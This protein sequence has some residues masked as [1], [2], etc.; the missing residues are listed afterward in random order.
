MQEMFIAIMAM[1][2]VNTLPDITEEYRNSMHNKEYSQ[3]VSDTYGEPHAYDKCVSKQSKNKTFHIYESVAC[4]EGLHFEGCRYLEHINLFV[5]N[6]E[7]FEI[8]MDNLLE[9]YGKT[10]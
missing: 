9:F 6:G 8:P 7:V 4:A 1:L 10:R 5:R 2:G 3:C